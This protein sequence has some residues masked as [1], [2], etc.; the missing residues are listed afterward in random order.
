MSSIKHTAFLQ[1]ARH[2]CIWAVL[3]VTIWIVYTCKDTRTESDYIPINPIVTHFSGV[4]FAGSETCAACHLAIYETHVETAHFNT[5]ALADTNT[6]KGNFTAG[7][8]TFNIGNIF[9]VTMTASDS[10]LTQ[11]VHQIDKNLLL[12]E[13]K[14]DVAFGSGA[15]GQSYLTWKDDR[16]FQL[17]ASYFS[18][19]QSWINS[20]GYIDYINHLRPVGARCME[21]H[22]TYAENIESGKIKNTY[23]KKQIIYGVDCER[24]HG[25]LAKHVGFHSSN[26]KVTQAKFIINNESLSRQQRL[27]A[28]ALCHSGSRAKSKQNPFSFMTGDKLSEFSETDYNEEDEINLDV[29]GNQYGLLS[30]SKCFK[31]TET[32]DCTTC[33][34]PHKNERGNTDAFNLKCINCHAKASIECKE[35]EIMLTASN[36]NCIKCHMPLLPS[37]SM[38]I[39]INNDTIPVQVR[40]HLIAVYDENP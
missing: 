27:D 33:H 35:D 21:C 28:C 6:V 23:N 11:T 13:A 12:F 24:C 8:N 37:K 17:Q 34:D 7:K 40:T 29:H 4:G 3:F 32:M 36:N 38:Q 15:K 25:P 18:P 19:T 22:T 30:N 5:S 1:T 39:Q 26:P 16:L 10:M 14:I 2:F 20:P 9:K 31:E